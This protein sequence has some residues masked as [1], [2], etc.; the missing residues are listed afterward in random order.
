MEG[1]AT[2]AERLMREALFAVARARPATEH[3]RNVQEVFRLAGTVPATFELKGEGAPQNG[4]KAEQ[5][6]IAGEIWRDSGPSAW[7]CV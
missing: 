4:S 7:S 1:S 2:V 3:V 6:R 5:D